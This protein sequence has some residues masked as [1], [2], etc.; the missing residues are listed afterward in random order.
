[1]S[2]ALAAAEISANVV[3]GLNRDHIFVPWE[4]RGDALQVI[5]ALT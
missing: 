2:K 5:A 3:A 4:R 1:L